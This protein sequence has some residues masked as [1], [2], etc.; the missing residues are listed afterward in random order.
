MK[1]ERETDF[2]SGEAVVRVNYYS[3]IIRKLIP[4]YLRAN[5]VLVCCFFM[6]HGSIK[7]YHLYGF[8]SGN[9]RRI[10]A[11]TAHLFIP[12]ARLGSVFIKEICDFI[13]NRYHA[14]MYNTCLHS[15][16]RQETSIAI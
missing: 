8:R 13:D 1:W 14:C 4:K 16:S 6:V 5:L 15:E 7:Y 2:Q 9:V 12:A 3:L 10:Y 11:V